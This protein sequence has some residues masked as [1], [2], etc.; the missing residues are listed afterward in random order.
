VGTKRRLSKAEELELIRLLEQEERELVSPKLEQLKGADFDVAIIRGGRGAGA[1]SHGVASLLLQELHYEQHRLVCLREVQNSIEE[2]VYQLLVDKLEQLRYTGWEITKNTLV[3][4]VGSK[5]IFRGLKDLRANRYKVFITYNPETESD[6]CTKQFW[7]DP[8]P[9]VIKIQMRPGKADNPWWNDALTKKMEKD[10]DRD[11]VLA[12]HVWN[13]NPLSQSDRA[14]MDREA[15]RQA[16][17]RNAPLGKPK[18]IGVDVARFGSDK[19]TVYIRQGM[20]VIGHYRWSKLD[21][22]EIARRVWDLSKRDPTVVIKVDDTGVGGGVSDK[23]KDI[24]ATVVP[25]NFGASPSD[26]TLYTTVADE[27]WFEFPI[28]EAQIPDDPMLV[29]ELGSR[30]YKYTSRDQRKIEDKEEFKKR[31][32]RSPDDADGLLLCF[33]EGK[34]KPIMTEDLRKAMRARNRR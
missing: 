26:K 19:T 9:R 23:L 10:F 33:Y 3:S 32:G 5:I 8:D 27:M 6:P 28:N 13:G 25:V 29:E 14:V 16:T 20:R 30:Q 34:T 15:I 1:K 11:P 31:M 17:L 18:E 24:G 4:P 2:S 21:T 22:Q 12:D 7:N